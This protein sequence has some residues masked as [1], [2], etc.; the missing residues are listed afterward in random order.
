MPDRGHHI[1]ADPEPCDGVF[2][3]EDRPVI[4]VV[5]GFP[6]GI[7]GFLEPSIPERETSRAR[8]AVVGN[9]LGG[10]GLVASPLC[11]GVVCC[12]QAGNPNG[13]SGC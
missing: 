13:L 2:R 7:E 1:L 5:L 8:I 3:Q 11:A 4:I 6:D 10:G 12:G 9:R